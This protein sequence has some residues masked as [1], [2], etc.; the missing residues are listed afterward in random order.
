MWWYMPVIQVLRRLSKGD[1]EFKSALGYTA[2]PQLK[3]MF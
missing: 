2:R 1:Q 3:E